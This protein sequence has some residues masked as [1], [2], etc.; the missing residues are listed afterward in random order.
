MPLRS[1]MNVPGN[2]TPS[3]RDRDRGRVKQ[4]V[5]LDSRRSLSAISGNVMSRDSVNFSSVSASRS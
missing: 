2:G 3:L 5:A 1:S 4:A